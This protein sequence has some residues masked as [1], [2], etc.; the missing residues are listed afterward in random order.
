MRVLTFAA[1]IV[2][3]CSGS[4]AKPPAAPVDDAPKL[5]I[6]GEWTDPEA[7]QP[8]A[9]AP[10]AARLEDAAR[11][12]VAKVIVLQGATILT[13]AGKRIGNGSIVLEGGAIKSVAEGAV[14]LPKDAEL[15]D[16]S[17]KFI[18]PGIIDT[19][20]HLGVYAQPSVTAHGDGNETSGA[21]TPQARAEYA[22]WPQ[23]PAISRAVA[24]GVTTAQI[25]PGSANLIGGRGF[26]VVM[27]RGRHADDVRF[28]GAPPT[29]K[30]ACGE[31][32]KRTHGAK[33][34]PTTRMGE[35][36]AFR[37]AF[38]QAAE[39][40]AKQKAYVRNRAL[41][42]KKRGRAAELDAEATRA[43]KKGRVAIEP[44][45]EPPPRDAKLDT[46]AGV[47]RGDVLV[48]IHCYRADEIRQMVAIAD[49]FGFRIRSFH[50]ATEAY[51]VRDLLAARDIAVSTWADWWGFKMESF[52]S[53]P[54]EAA[55]LQQ[56]GARPVIKSDSAIGMQRLN[57]EAGKAMYA[58]RAAGI[59]V[60]EDQA[61]R[62]ITANAA[63]V[64]GI[65]SVV[66]T[67]EA[68]KRADLVVW[69]AHPF[70]VYAKA[71]VVVQGGEVVYRRDVGLVP[72]DFELGNSALQDQG[73]VQ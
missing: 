35:Y 25:L 67:L 61:L 16:A 73:G 13:A 68:G 58:G 51:K 14:A 63:W 8:H 38:Q 24:G 22:Y 12:P 71:D 37:D 56:A 66:G 57:Q 47:L 21:I 6:P 49:Q 52:D 55:L 45:P 59:D 53:I 32:P 69:S 17:G 50:H 26:T 31:N 46:L 42:V 34:G 5:D 54:E 4:T 70:S 11:N 30:M 10:V 2:A 9:V 15:I 28:P 3:A 1:L 39:Y 44:A 18:T 29:I 72:T 40:D 20:S 36:A 62:W 41:W 7:D 19:H 48:Q 60:T 33:G 27:R 65:D 64:L 43:G 23:D